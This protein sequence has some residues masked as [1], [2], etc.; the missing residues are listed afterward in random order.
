MFKILMNAN[1]LDVIDPSR[2]SS[3]LV[4]DQNRIHEIGNAELIEKYASMAEIEN[5]GGRFILPGF[6][7]AHIHLQEY[8]KSLSKID[9]ETGTKQEALDRI[10]KG[11]RDLKPGEWLLGH[12]WQQNDWGGDFPTKDDIDLLVPNN[13]A[14]LTG[15]S[16]HVAWC[17]SRALDLV[18]I[19]PKT[20]DPVN[21]KIVLGADGTPT[22][23]LLETAM[24]LVE[25][26]MPE[27]NEFQ[28]AE[29]IQKCLPFLL[30]FG[31]T[32][33]HDFDYKPAF[34]ALQLLD[35]DKKLTLRVV[36]NIPVSLLS[37]ATELGLRTGV[38]SDFLKIG[39][40]KVFMDGA[41]GPRT[42][43]MVEPYANEESNKGILNM[44][45]EEFF[46]I[47][48]KAADSGLGMTGHA[49]GDL[50]VHE[51]LAGYERLRQ[52][53]RDNQYQPLR[54]RIEHVQVI[55]PKDHSKLA[56]LGIVASMQP[57]HASSDM[58]SADKYWGERAKLSYAWKTQL[59]TGATLA[60]GSD[61]PVESPNP[62]WGLYAAVSR[63][64]ILAPSPKSWREEQCLTIDEAIRAY[65]V[66]PAFAGYQES[67][68]GQLKPGFFAD[69]IV[70]DQNPYL[71]DVER[72]KNLLP[73]KTMVNGKWV[74]SAE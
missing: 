25:R 10:K 60:F 12:G 56:E 22:G 39:S 58:D 6:T 2:I 24:H 30:K 40:I 46:E 59:T 63:K 21:G 7:D 69:L 72:L 13:P 38:G 49:I 34:K 32:S 67:D 51:I 1:I 47:A 4:L 28:I 18:G 19:N 73:V 15:K 43:A 62:F 66:G 74:W 23:I 37:F 44:D 52:Y 11:A 64:K 53:E 5:M 41:L 3:V 45:G 20:P 54:H 31:I 50:A 36:K 71:C 48:S 16:L 57:I 26:K 14:Y 70:L 29:L 17:N 8:A 9:L 33:V 68:L 55:H 27:L 65:T 35:I 61:S 42:A